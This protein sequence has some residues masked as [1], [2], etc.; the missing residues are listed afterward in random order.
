[1]QTQ[2]EVAWNLGYVDKT[3]F[4]DLENAANQIAKMLSTLIRR[5]EDR[6]EAHAKSK[7]RSTG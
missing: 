4:D 3:T 2:M 5:L 6:R 7:P 1:L